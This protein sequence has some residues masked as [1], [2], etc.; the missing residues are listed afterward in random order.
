[1]LKNSHTPNS[2]KISSQTHY[3][4]RL[5]CCREG[6]RRTR[7]RVGQRTSWVTKF[8]YKITSRGGYHLGLFSLHV[9]TTSSPPILGV[10][11]LLSPFFSYFD[12]YH[13]YH[14]RHS[15]LNILSY[16]HIYVHTRLDT[17]EERARHSLFTRATHMFSSTLPIFDSSLTKITKHA[18]LVRF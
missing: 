12:S 6:A 17:L 3:F 5:C 4:F 13:A 18:N 7:A 9:H 16:I 8:W 15:P 11:S 14:T 1:M 2:T 10:V